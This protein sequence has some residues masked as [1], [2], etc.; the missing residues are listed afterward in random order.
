MLL[1]AV[2]APASDFASWSLWGTF[3]LASAGPMC[4]VFSRIGCVHHCFCVETV[5]NSVLLPVGT[6]VASYFG[7]ICCS[8]SGVCV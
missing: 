5:L 2:V 4:R 6:G 1:D 7:V 3:K 8:R